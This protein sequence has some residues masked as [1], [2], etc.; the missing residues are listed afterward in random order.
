MAI[1]KFPPTAEGEAAARAVPE[2]KYLHF[3]AG[4][5]EVW[6]EEH[7]TPPVSPTKDEADTS[8][9]RQ[10]GKL[11]ALAHMSPSEVQTWCAANVTTIAQARDAITTLA[12]AVSI[13]A[14]RL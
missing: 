13:L 8:T 7:Y 3:C 9:A 4:C 6:T 12:I 5:F 1:L 11:Q 2:P 10:H 14:R